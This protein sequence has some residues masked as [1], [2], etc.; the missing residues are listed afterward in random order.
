[1]RPGSSSR[2]SFGAA[3]AERPSKPEPTPQP[4]QG[5]ATRPR[6]GSTLDDPLQAPEI[7]LQHPPG[8]VVEA[9]QAEATALPD[10]RSSPVGGRRCR[11]V[12][13]RD[14]RHGGTVMPPL[15][16]TQSSVRCGV[17][18]STRASNLS[19][20]QPMRRTSVSC[21]PSC[22]VLRSLVS[23]SRQPGHQCCQ[24]WGSARNRQT[25]SGAAAI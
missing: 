17:A 23:A 15:L 5:S 13:R 7:L 11:W 25:I 2:A 24:L 8:G 18:A 1:M 19:V 21:D 3:S 4:G 10:Q 12:W 22:R 14:R 6:L 20:I 16:L 9:R